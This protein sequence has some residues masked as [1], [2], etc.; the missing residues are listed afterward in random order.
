MI[1]K[2]EVSQQRYNICKSCSEFRKITRTCKVCN[3]FMVLKTKLISSECPLGKW[4]S[5]TNSWSS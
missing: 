4:K 2:A 5:P 3:C 1:V